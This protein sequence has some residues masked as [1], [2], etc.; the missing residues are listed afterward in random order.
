MRIPASASLRASVVVRRPET[1]VFS[2]ERLIP[3]EAGSE[4]GTRTSMLKER[5]KRSNGLLQ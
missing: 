2:N 1:R 4:V 5:E 3:Q